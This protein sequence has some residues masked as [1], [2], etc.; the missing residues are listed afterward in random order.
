MLHALTPLKTTQVDVFAL[1]VVCSLFFWNPKNNQIAGFKLINLWNMGTAR[2]KISTW[3]KSFKF[4]NI[5]N[6][7]TFKEIM[8]KLFSTLKT[9]ILVS[10]LVLTY[11]TTRA[12]IS[13]NYPKCY[14]NATGA[15]K[16]FRIVNLNYR[17]HNT[18]HAR[19]N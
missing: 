7:Y 1:R 17:K 18:T 12:V 9:L 16:L 10:M 6:V 3:K 19:F 2:Y 11:H 8:N 14:Q 5:I 4:L 15:R 13:H